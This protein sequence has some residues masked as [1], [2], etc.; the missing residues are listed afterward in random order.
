M[1]KIKNFVQP[2]GVNYLCQACFNNIAKYEINIENKYKINLC[3]KCL[4]ELRN[5]EVED[6]SISM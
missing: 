4:S 2:K 3:D 5:K 1:I 6:D